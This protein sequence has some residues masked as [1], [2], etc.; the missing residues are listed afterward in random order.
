MLAFD[1]VLKPLHSF[2][3]LSTNR[4]LELVGA[5][6]KMSCHV[7]LESRQCLEGFLTALHVQGN[8]A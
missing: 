2:E 5:G 6:V 1:V 8:M 7:V 4:A 3:D